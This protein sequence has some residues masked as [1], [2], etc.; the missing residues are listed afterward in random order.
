MAAVNAL[1]LA[2]LTLVL[3]DACLAMLTKGWLRESDRGWRPSDIPEERARAREMRLRGLEKWKLPALVDFLPFPIQLSLV[4]FFIALLIMLFDLHRPIAYATI[5]VF[6]VSIGVYLSATVVSALDAT[7]PFTS[8]FS[9]ALH[10]LIRNF[11][12]N[13][14]L[15]MSVLRRTTRMDTGNAEVTQD[16]MGEIE[17]HLAI[18]NRLYAVTSKAVENLPVFIGLFDQWVDVPY[19]HPQ[20]MSEWRTVLHFIQPCLSEVSFLKEFGPRS[21][22]R[23]FLCSDAEDFYLGQQAVIVALGKD[24]GESPSVERLYIHLLRQQGP[25][26][27]L[28][29]QVVPNL[30][31]ERRTI[32]ELRWILSWIFFRFLIKS[33]E[34]PNKFDLSWISSVRNII[35][36][37]HSVAIYIIQKN[38]MNDDHRLFHSLLFVTQLI[39][40]GSKGLRGGDMPHSNIQGG[41]FTS[42][43]VSSLSPD[44]QWQVICDLYTASS[45]SAA[46]LK[47][48]FSQLVVLLMART[49][50]RVKHSDINST[51]IHDN[52][53]NLPVL[54]DGLW[55]AWTLP[56]IDHCSLV[57]I[58]AW[59][60][61]QPSGSFDQT[62]PIQGLLDAYD[63]YAS[64]PIPIMNPNALL[65]IERALLF[66]REGENKW[67]P[68]TNKLKT[69]GL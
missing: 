14:S 27:S 20:S 18:S 56:G 59:L 22:A 46:G 23:L 43:G 1:L 60:L 53:E 31:A 26:W 65:F 34:F 69:L 52:P 9:R 4:L 19:L 32:I 38:F 3:L 45:K 64:G 15:L 42:I 21:L 35:S 36:F 25:N 68:Q 2:S 58:A 49:L 24:G 48:D 57:R 12:D 67:E 61:K 17:T 10:V 30:D 5:G 51:V 47:H 13:L 44:T 40:N 66:S 16:N 39:A 7:A 33:Q 63:S 55:E 54:M 41:L 37:L 62:R 50:T 8:D 29:C 11:S 28:A 6:T